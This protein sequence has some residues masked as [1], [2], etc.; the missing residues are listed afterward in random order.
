[1]EVETELEEVLR[2]LMAL[3]LEEKMQAVGAEEVQ[4]EKPV[5]FRTHFLLL[6]WLEIG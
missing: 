3:L 1:M 2:V 6:A 5:H 4:L